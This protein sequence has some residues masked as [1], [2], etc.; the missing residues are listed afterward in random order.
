MYVTSYYTKI[1]G[2]F[3]IELKAVLAMEVMIKTIDLTKIY[4][5]RIKAVDNLNL[6]IYSGCLL[7]TSPSPR[8]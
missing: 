4:A 7:Y 5:G 6:E 3:F 1:K 8:D 2:T